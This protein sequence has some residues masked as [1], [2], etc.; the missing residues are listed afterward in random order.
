M[1]INIDI[2][3]ICRISTELIDFFKNSDTMNDRPIYYA[4][5]NLKMQLELKGITISDED[6]EFKNGK[7]L[8]KNK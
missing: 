6:I 3:E 8:I 7:F 2:E 5:E 1:S 4:K